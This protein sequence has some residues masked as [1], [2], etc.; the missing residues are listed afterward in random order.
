M[1]PIIPA[2][3]A[4][5]HTFL[6]GLSQFL[7]L[8]F[9]EK[10]DC[11]NKEIAIKQQAQILADHLRVP[12]WCCLAVFWCK[13]QQN[14]HLWTT[15]LTWCGSICD[16]RAFPDSRLS[17]QKWFNLIFPSLLSYQT[18]AFLSYIGGALS[19]ASLNSFLSLPAVI[20]LGSFTQFHVSICH[21][22]HLSRSR[23]F[24]MNNSVCLTFQ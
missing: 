22:L 24:G 13:I 1:F 23:Q 18:G 2:N 7:V 9:T 6:N 4:Q 20:L 21:C 12:G 8:S 11:K 17:P 15:C 3:T 5:H 10:P 14:H 16:S 19:L